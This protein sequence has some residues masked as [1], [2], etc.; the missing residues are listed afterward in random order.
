MS[1]LISPRNAD[2]RRSLLS[3]VSLLAIAASVCVSQEAAA[4]D[5]QDDRPLVWIELGGQMEKQ[6]GQGD[7][8]IPDFVAANESSPGFSGVDF[9][10]QIGN[11]LS[12]GFEGSLSF[13]PSESEW[14]FSASVRYG[15][16]NVQKDL[17]HATPGH[18]LHYKTLYLTPGYKIRCCV[19][20]YYTP[21]GPR[22]YSGMQSSSNQA[23]MV[24]DFLAGRDVGL[25]MFGNHGSSVISAGVRFAQFNSHARVTIHGRPHLDWQK[26]MHYYDGYSY[27]RYVQLPTHRY[28]VTENS[29]RSFHVE[30]R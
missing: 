18:R 28:S 29:S 13:Q 15:R 6:T 14:Q 30:H 5:S 25:G 27:Y 12:N 1:E 26:R 17:A 19:T 11:G 22:A 21:I 20:G 2:L 4:S 3:T 8:F 10:S 23:H 16:A 24:L 7:A 9:H